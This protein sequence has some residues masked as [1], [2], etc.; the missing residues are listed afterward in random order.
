MTKRIFHSAFF[1]SVITMLICMILITGILFGFF[2]NQ[3]K[4]ELAYEADYIALTLQKNN[5]KSIDGFSSF[6]KRITL[7]NPDGSV[8]YDSDTDSA[9]MSS[10]ADRPE[11]KQA[12]EKGSGSDVRYSNTLTEK[13]IYYAKKLE[14]GIVLRVSTTQYTVTSLLS[15]LTFPFIIVFASA[16]ALSFIL[17]LQVSK[18]I[19]S[20]IN[21]I[22]IDSPE[23]SSAYDE[24]APLL[25]K[26]INQ[27]DTIQKQI[28][29][30]RQKQ[31]EFNLIT[32]N[33]SE[34]F[35]II[36][37]N[38]NLLSSNSAALNLLDAEKS[39]GSVLMLNHSGD[40][41]K[42]IK[43]SLD[44]NRA[45][46]TMQ[47]ADRTYKLIS[48]PVFE[49]KKLIGA[50][51]IIIDITESA[52]NE[53]IRREFAANVS[54]EL[55]TPLTSISGFAELMKDGGVPAETAADFSNTIYTEAQRLITL[56]NDII[57][58]SELDE[59]SEHFLSEEVD[60]FELSKEVTNRLAHSAEKKNISMKVTG[61][62]AAICGTRR[63]LDEMI[64]NLCDNAIKYNKDGGSVETIIKNEDDKVIL[65]IRDTGIGIPNAY[66]ERIFERFFRIDKSRS[67]VEGGTGLGLSIVKHG[68]MYH[69]AAISVDSTVGKGTAI[70]I[71]FPKK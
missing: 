22:N 21:S 46:N 4:K 40:F 52:E 66:R 57:K 43:S 44:G 38:A 35:L 9:A 31:E 47:H 26:I 41:I 53:N 5:I 34:G 71:I 32:E 13:T 61:T 8:S 29:E 60:L 42:T 58:I 30:A 68:A 39:E 63:I 48:T 20:P 59:H 2:E 27:R 33:M 49:E 3:I 36:D 69:H 37:K 17:S 70:T 25:K 23:N 45:E 18:K 16:L 50:V 11:F 24:L 6:G 62:N 65:T 56:V 1:V 12:I 54:H 14:N 19:I 67:K 15:G 64:Y 10:H 55:K 7:I 51:I 28:A